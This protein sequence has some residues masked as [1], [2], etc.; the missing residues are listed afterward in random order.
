MI[1]VIGSIN[2]DICFKVPHIPQAGES[3]LAREMFDN[4]GGKGANQAVSAAKLGGDVVLLGSV[5]NDAHGKALLDSLSHAGVCT[6]Y[7]RISDTASSGA[8][9]ICI[10]DNGENA[11]VANPGANALV[12]PDFVREHEALFDKAEYCV[13][14][15]E[16]PLETVRT[17]VALC[18]AKG[19][20]IIFNPSPLCPLEDDLLRGIDYLVPNEHEIADL[21]GKKH[22]DISDS[23]YIAFAESRGVGSMVVTLGKNGCLLVDTH[24]QVSRFP[25]SHHKPV[26][27]TGAGDTFLGAFTAALSQG[28]A[29]EKA[30][31]FATQASGIAVTR[32][33]AQQAMPLREEVQI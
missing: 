23:D 33:G 13:L 29:I 28:F 3:L 22:A 10:S 9:Y 1:L 19:V 25:A 2:M 30:I 5:G 18:R 31:A 15:L 11:I 12:T 17:T 14:Q 27:T 16:V 26:D 7:I 32:Y 6:D 24:R 4:P 21:I 20:K 8:A